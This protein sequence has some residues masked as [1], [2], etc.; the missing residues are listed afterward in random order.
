MQGRKARQRSAGMLFPYL[1]VLPA[2]ALVIIL[3]VLPIGETIYR[4][5]TNWDG[6]TSSFIG[7]T[8]FRLI[9]S[10][11]GDHPGLRSTRSSS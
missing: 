3:M 1:A 11:P 9:F 4:S 2:A 8:N 7:M 10:E 5:F 6:L